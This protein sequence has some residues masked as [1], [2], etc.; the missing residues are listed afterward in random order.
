M[1]VE[2]NINEKLP[3]DGPL[4]RCTAQKYKRPEDDKEY[5]VQIWISHHSLMDGVSSMALTAS[6][7]KNYSKDL[8]IKFNPVSLFMKTVL[9]LMIP[10]QLGL[11]LTNSV[12]TGRDVNKLTQNKKKMTGKV[13]LASSKLLSVAEMKAVSKKSG[14]TINDIVMSSMS[15]AMHE[16]LDIKED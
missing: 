15:T 11:L 12:F 4:W 8:F 3:I 7:T 10:F 16:Y 5:L 6:C 2:D 9:R 13:N 14:I 1:F